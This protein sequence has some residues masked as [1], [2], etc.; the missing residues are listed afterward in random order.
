MLRE[1][2]DGQKHLISQ[3]GEEGVGL[4]VPLVEDK[5]EATD[6]RALSV[7]D[8]VRDRDVIEEH[9]EVIRPGVTDPDL[10]GG[11]PEVRGQVV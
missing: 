1:V 2:V 11:H 7:E 3:W 5:G 4:P 9:D 10:I 6:R 8:P